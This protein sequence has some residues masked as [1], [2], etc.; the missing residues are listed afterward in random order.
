MFENML[1]NLKVFTE[2]AKKE[3]VEY[4]KELDDFITYQKIQKIDRLSKKVDKLTDD[5]NET[6]YNNKNDFVED[7]KVTD[8]D[9]STEEKLNE[10]EKE[11]FSEFFEEINHLEKI[12]KDKIEKAKKDER[13]QKVEQR[14]NDAAEAFVR[15]FKEDNHRD[16]YCPECE[17]CK[18][19]GY[20]A[21]GFCQY[22]A[23]SEEELKARDDFEKENYC[24]EGCCSSYDKCCDE[25]DDDLNSDDYFF[26]D[27]EDEVEE[28]E[29]VP[30]TT[31]IKELLKDENIEVD[32]KKIRDFA[33]EHGINLEKVNNKFVASKD[34]VMD[35]FN[36]L[37]NEFKK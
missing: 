19:Y 9:S 3:S 1:E 29:M 32:G 36:D 2:K 11:F 30:F 8:K 31:T 33:N 10:K 25:D 4:K 20:C 24:C 26:D 12:V 7:E 5:V 35:A 21:P 14:I 22:N 28:E 34:I 17:N 13:A 27:G 15:E 6:L 23:C 18:K 37:K 16:N